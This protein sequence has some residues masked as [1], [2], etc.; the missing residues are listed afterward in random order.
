MAEKTSKTRATL[1]AESEGS[2]ATA[3]SAAASPNHAAEANAPPLEAITSATQFPWDEWS[4]VRRTLGQDSQSEFEGSRAKLKDAAAM[5]AIEIANRPNYDW[6]GE[7]ADLMLDVPKSGHKYMAATVATFGA[8]ASDDKAKKAR[9]AFLDRMALSVEWLAARVMAKPDAYPADEAGIETLVK[10]IDEKGGMARIA[11]LQRDLNGGKR[12][13]ARRTAKIALDPATVR[14][15]RIERARKQLEQGK[16]SDG[17]VVKLGFIYEDGSQTSVGVTLAATD[18]RLEQA[19]LDMEVI[20]PLVDRLGEL[21]QAGQMVAEEET[22][23]LADPL[24]D[25]EDPEHGFRNAFRHFVFVDGE[26]VVISPILVSSSVIVRATPIVGL[27][28]EALDAPCHLRTRERRIME[29][30]IADRERRKVFSGKVSSAGKTSGVF[31]FEVKTEAAA[32]EKDNGRNVGV[33][34]EPLRSTQGN[35]P[36]TIDLKRLTPSIEGHISLVAWKSRHDGYVAIATKPVGKAAGIRQKHSL[37]PTSWKIVSSKKDDARDVTGTGLVTDVEVMAG[38]FYRVSQI[39][40]TLPVIGQITV[41]AERHTGLCLAFATQ[42]FSYEVYIPALTTS[43][44]RTAALVAPF[45]LP[46]SP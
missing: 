38:D 27:F 10:L 5:L 23:A 37:S 41:R 20:D 6:A 35:L 29:A 18:E 19:L 42:H 28:S 21:L 9:S 45:K 15:E 1:P 30:N 17:A 22:T 7:A 31:R 4:H 26:P 11:G 24:D 34:V 14:N 8:R 2:I 40:A 46:N 32:N 33:L 12:Q 13:P 43:G 25:P 3:E 36:L 44:D 39:I 16:P